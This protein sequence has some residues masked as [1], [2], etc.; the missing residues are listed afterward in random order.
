M[1]LGSGMVAQVGLAHETTYGTAVTVTRFL[2]LISESLGDGVPERL[3]SE[4]IVA[5]RR[6]I[7]SDQWDGGEISIDGDVQIH[8]VRQGTA[9][10]WLAAFGTVASASTGGATTHT[11]TPGDLSGRSLTVQVGRPQVNGVVTPYTYA[12][13]KV[14]SWEMTVE[15]GGRPTVSYTLMAQSVTTATA[16]AAAA[17]PVGVREYVYHHGYAVVGGVTQTVRGWTLSGD[18]GLSDDR[19]HLGSQLYSEPLEVGLRE[20]TGTLTIE[21]SSTAAY[22]AAVTGTEFAVVLGMSASTTESLI[23][24]LNARYDGYP[25]NVGGRNLLVPEVP[26]KAVASTTVDSSAISVALR[27]AQATAA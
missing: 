13:C 12:G 24:T 15:A 7:L 20:Y 2:P 23:T 5:G 26:F 21:W 3:E 6:V 8:V 25:V 1:P 11:F 18:N 9:G 10:L 17:F 14:M 22:S 19:M 4:G 16:L 27:N